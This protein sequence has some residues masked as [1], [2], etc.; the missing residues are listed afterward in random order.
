MKDVTFGKDNLAVT[1]SMT[2][3]G[4]RCQLHFWRTDNFSE[5]THLDYLPIP[6]EECCTYALG[7]DKNFVTVFQRGTTRRIYIVSTKTRTI[8]EKITDSSIKLVRY[9]QGLLIMSYPSFIR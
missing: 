3:T 8:V 2:K 5:I 1:L 6:E 9:E 7:M 4:H